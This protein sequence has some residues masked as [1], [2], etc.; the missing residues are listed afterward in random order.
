MLFLLKQFLYTEQVYGCI[1]SQDTI[2]RVS[3]TATEIPFKCKH[4]DAEF[5]IS[6]ADKLTAPQ[7]CN[8]NNLTTKIIKNTQAFV[9]HRKHRKIY[10]SFLICFKLGFFFYSLESAKGVRERC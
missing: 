8:L 2:I 6:E 4:Q 9:S 5:I 1:Y 7:S 10:F 3:S